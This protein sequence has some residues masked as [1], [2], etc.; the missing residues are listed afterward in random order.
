MNQMIICQ[1][2]YHV[3]QHIILEKKQLKIQIQD[4]NSEP[5][6]DKIQRETTGQD[7]LNQMF[8]F[9]LQLILDLLTE[10]ELNSLKTNVQNQA[11]KFYRK[12]KQEMM[13]D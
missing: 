12:K 6:E 7:Q 1:S 8:H 11:K 10:E 5:T 9:N 2:K 3:Q 4:G 13:M